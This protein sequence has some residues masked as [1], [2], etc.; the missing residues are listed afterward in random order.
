MSGPDFA[1]TIADHRVNYHSRNIGGQASSTLR[2]TG[3]H[4]T[5]AALAALAQRE[6]ES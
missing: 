1:G 5:T 2:Y 3:E 6:G 4:L